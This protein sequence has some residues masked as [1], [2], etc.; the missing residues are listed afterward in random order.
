MKKISLNATLRTDL[1]KPTTKKARKNGEVMAILYGYKQKNIACSLPMIDVN[2][3]VDTIEPCFIELKLEGK[4]YRCIIND[5]QYHPVSDI[6]LHVDLLQI[7]EERPIRLD[8]PVVFEGKE[9]SPGLLSGGELAIK[10]RTVSVKALPKNM[11]EKLAVD[12]SSLNLG[13]KI[14]VGEAPK[15][16]YTIVPQPQIPLAIVNIPRALRSK[17]ASEKAA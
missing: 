11:P 2:E 13:E 7:N 9:K 1:R 15:G 16:D 8:I 14:T 17:E 3:I 5:V 12:V 4:S 6:V 10:K